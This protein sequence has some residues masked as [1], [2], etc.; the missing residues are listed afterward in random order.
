MTKG[1]FMALSNDRGYKSYKDLVIEIG[2]SKRC[3][4]RYKK[5]Q[6]LSS[7]FIK[8]LDAFIRNSEI[9]LTVSNKDYHNSDKLSASKIKLILENPVIFNSAYN[10]KSIANKYSNALLV[11][12]AHHSKVLEPDKYE[13]EYIV[14]GLERGLKSEIVEAIELMGG[15]LDRKENK[16]NEL[17]VTQTIPILKDMLND[18]R[19]LEKRT[20]LTKK[21]HELAFITSEK[22]LNSMFVVEGKSGN[23]LL[24]ESL[25]D[26]IS[27]NSCHVERTFYGTIEGVDFQVRP[28]LLVDLGKDNGVWFCVDLKTAE[29]ATMPVFSKQSAQ[30]FY[31][32]QEYI[33]REILRQNE[34]NL[35]DFRFC[36]TGKAEGS[37]SAYYRLSRDD[38]EDAKEITKKAIQKPRSILPAKHR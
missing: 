18:L 17:I 26:I 14:L 37:K 21:Q 8:R 11:G 9:G 16:K 20:I 25:R 34:I 2:Y 32:I 28:D 38:I 15:K 30:F 3:L 13:E 22:A 1:E 35:V 7:V 27:L 31:D 4:D 10:T 6:K 24:K 12:C 23:I 33:Y 29:N 5:D 36:V 19:H